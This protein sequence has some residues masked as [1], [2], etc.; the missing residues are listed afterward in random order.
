LAIDFHGR[1]AIPAEQPGMFVGFFAQPTEI[2]V[3]PEVA[4]FSAV[5][6]NAKNGGG[7]ATGVVGV[8][9]PVLPGKEITEVGRG[10]ESEKGVGRMN[11]SLVE[12][13]QSRRCGCTFPEGCVRGCP[14][15]TCFGVLKSL[16]GIYPGNA[17]ALP[18][19]KNT[20]PV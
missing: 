19:G 6:Q 10:T 2:C 4:D 16:K 7:I 17:F 1:E 11:Q 15:Q 3:F 12:E 5:S 13:V 9:S 18:A 20:Q 8:P 14:T